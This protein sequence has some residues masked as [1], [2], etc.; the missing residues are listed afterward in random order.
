MPGQLALRNVSVSLAGRSVLHD[1]SLTVGPDSR[2][3]LLG[4]NGVGKTTLL[5]TAP[6]CC[7]PI[8]APSSARP[9]T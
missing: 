9:T 1:V 8:A 3:G 6:D 5:S 2:V 7:R 4:P